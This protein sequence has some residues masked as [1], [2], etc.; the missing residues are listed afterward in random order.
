MEIISFQMQFDGGQD[1]HGKVFSPRLVFCLVRRIYSSLISCSYK[2]T[3]SQWGAIEDPTEP[4]THCPMGS[5]IRASRFQ[6][7]ESKIGR[8]ALWS[9]G[10]IHVFPGWQNYVSFAHMLSDVGMGGGGARHGAGVGGGQGEGPIKPLCV[11]GPRIFFKS[12]IS[13]TLVVL[14][15]PST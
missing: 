15:S 8:G 4:R 3:D 5:A 9:R 14:T 7:W 12:G 1:F 10:L 2:R 6:S 11:G 13:L